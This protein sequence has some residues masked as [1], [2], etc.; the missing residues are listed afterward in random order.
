MAAIFHWYKA[1]PN[2]P[3]GCVEKRIISFGS[4]GGNKMIISDDKMQ[5]HFAFEMQ[6]RLA[7]SEGQRVSVLFPF[8][9]IFPF[10]IVSSVAVL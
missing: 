9:N 6:L 3:E 1:K 5:S 4:P 2:F 8:L 7:G 10:E